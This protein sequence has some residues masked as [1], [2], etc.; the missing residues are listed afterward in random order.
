MKD[1]D[2]LLPQH[3]KNS[4]ETLSRWGKIFSTMGQGSIMEGTADFTEQGGNKEPG[5]FA[6]NH[7]AMIEGRFPFG[8]TLLHLSYTRFSSFLK[9]C[10]PSCK[11]LS[12]PCRFFFFQ[13]IGIRS[14]QYL[15]FSQW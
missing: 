10:I 14:N 8:K 2:I 6:Y 5:V 4:L 11:L 15:K 12:S 9:L 1:S 13:S 3:L 7:I